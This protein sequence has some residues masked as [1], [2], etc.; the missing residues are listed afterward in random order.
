[1][2]SAKLHLLKTRFK[3]ADQ[4]AGLLLHHI[5]NIAKLNEY[6]RTDLKEFRLA[7]SEREAF[8]AKK[9]RNLLHI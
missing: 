6:D 2:V 1:M 9:E 5:Q 3:K 7:Q 4:K 8:N